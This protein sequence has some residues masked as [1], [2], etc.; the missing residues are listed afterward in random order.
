MGIIQFQKIPLLLLPSF[1]HIS[2]QQ[3]WTMPALPPTPS[4]A[5]NHYTAL[6][7]IRLDAVSSTLLN[8]LQTANLF[9][10]KCTSLKQIYLHAS[11]PLIQCNRNCMVGQGGN[12]FSWMDDNGTRQ[13]KLDKNLFQA[14]KTW[15]NIQKLLKVKNQTLKYHPAFFSSEEKCLSNKRTR[16][17]NTFV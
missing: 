11:T 5:H 2:K 1:H 10:E 6:I 16:F 3:S 7:Q 13:H 12:S 17:I 14:H 15:L 8:Y 4:G 9:W